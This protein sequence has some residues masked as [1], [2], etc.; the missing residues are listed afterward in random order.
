MSILRDYSKLAE[1]AVKNG[2]DPERAAKL[3]VDAEAPIHYWLKGEERR[4][5]L[6]DRLSAREELE[7]AAGP[8]AAPTALEGIGNQYVVFG[9]MSVDRAVRRVGSFRNIDIAKPEVEANYGGRGMNLIHIG[10]AKVQHP[11]KI[12]FY[13]PA[14]GYVAVPS[15]LVWDIITLLGV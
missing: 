2:M 7:R 1:T 9:Y 8:K 11:Q 4:R 6:A 13:K 14:A 3:S 5:A 10:I 12:W 15:A